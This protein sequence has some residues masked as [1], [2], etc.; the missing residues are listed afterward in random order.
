MRKLITL[1]L[2]LML[3]LP[4]AATAEILA[5]GWQDAPVDELLAAGQAI[6]ERVAQLRAAQSTSAEG[7]LFQG[8]GTSILNDVAIPADPSRV[9]LTS[10]KGKAKATLSGGAYDIV[11]EIKDGQTQEFMEKGGTY[12]L[13]VE[14]DGDWS[15]EVQPIRQGGSLPL[16]GSGAYVS[17]FF[18]L[19]APLIVSI[20]A[21]LG[22][23]TDLLSLTTLRLHHQYEVSEALWQDRVLITNLISSASPD[24]SGDIILSPVKGRDLYVISVDCAPGVSWSIIPK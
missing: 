22:E 18:P 16:E 17:D 21:D 5:P 1:A 8:S 9:I 13:L 14:A 10:L 23:M 19:T 11:Y 7:L 24:M 6:N 20:K 12:T 3:A 4:A 15:F 2:V